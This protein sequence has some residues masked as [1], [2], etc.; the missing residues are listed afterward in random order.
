MMIDSDVEEGASSSEGL[1]TSDEE[2][3]DGHRI[4]EEGDVWTFY[5]KIHEK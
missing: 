5:H 4:R 2:T 3:K 1:Y